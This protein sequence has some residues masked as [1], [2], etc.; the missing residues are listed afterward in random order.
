MSIENNIINIRNVN[1]RPL[2]RLALIDNIIENK[3]VEENNANNRK[4]V[5]MKKFLNHSDPIT[6][7]G[8]YDGYQNC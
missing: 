6:P 7:G 5:S 3:P 4:K 8:Y 2:P 1:S